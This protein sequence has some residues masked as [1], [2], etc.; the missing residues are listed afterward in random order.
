[1]AHNTSHYISEFL[2]IN[3]AVESRLEKISVDASVDY[4]WKGSA[5][6]PELHRL[7]PW[8]KLVIIMREPLSRLISYVRMYTQRGHEVKGCLGDRNMY[9]CLQYHL[10]ANEANSNYSIPLEAWFDYFPPEQ[11]H[12][13]QFEELQVDPN[14]VVRRLKEFLGMDPDLPKRQLKNTNLRKSGGYNMTKDDYEGLLEQVQWDAERV[15]SLLS[16]R[17]LADKVT[18]LSR[19]EKVWDENLETCDE[20]GMCLINSN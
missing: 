14:A 17:G 4:A 11:F 5:L 15:A 20:T 3:D 9:D 19:W 1:M 6:A 12:V 8:I 18:W 2:R 7:F 10:D 16:S 13:I